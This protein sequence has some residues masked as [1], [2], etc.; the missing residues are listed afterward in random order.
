[1]KLD[2]AALLPA[3]E[4]RPHTARRRLLLKPQEQFGY[5]DLMHE[6]DLAFPSLHG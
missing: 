1:M 3:R 2:G 5:L 6:T 4:H